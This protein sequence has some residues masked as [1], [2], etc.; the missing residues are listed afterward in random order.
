MVKWKLMLTTL[1]FVAGALALKW[2]LGWGLGFPG[3]VDFADIGLV[4]TGGV[5][6]VGFMLAGT[7]ADFKESERLPGELAC[8]LETIE[9]CFATVAATKPALDLRIARNRIL[10]TADRIQDWLHRRCA[11]DD[12]FR[13]VEELAAGISELERAGST[14]VA[15]RALN[16]LNVLRKSL[17]RIHVISK[18]GFLASGYALLE[19]LTALIVALMMLARFKSALAELILV[20]FVTLIFVYMLRL[21]RDIDDPFEYDTDGTPGAAEVELFPLADYQE[22]L[23]ARLGAGPS[24]R[25]AK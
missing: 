15:V 13:G 5:F 19:V 2:L 12:M 11:V 20:S 4:L 21:I 25:A 9:E 1:P 8:Q 22:R 17:T 3:V 7:M 18:T 16:E 14:P 24:E 23:A 10:A 6:L